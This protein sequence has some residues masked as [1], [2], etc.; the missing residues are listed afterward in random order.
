MGIRFKTGE[1][2]PRQEMVIQLRAEGM[3][4]KQV[5][6]KMGLTESTAKQYMCKATKKTGKT[7]FEMVTD[8]A[9]SPQCT[10]CLYRLQL[11]EIQNTLLENG[12]AE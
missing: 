1:L 11:E 8:R 3:T 2:S 5:G 10:V 4:F 6:E 12:Y 9:R 7:P